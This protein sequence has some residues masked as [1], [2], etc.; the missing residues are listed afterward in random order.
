MDGA[1]A[2]RSSTPM[3]V[4]CS[5]HSASSL[6]ASRLKTR[7]LK[8]R[9][10]LGAIHSG[11]GLQYSPCTGPQLQRLT[12]GDVLETGDALANC[13]WPQG[14]ERRLDERSQ[15]GHHATSPKIR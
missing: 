1:F 8:G 11:L 5:S 12:D 14:R 7:A 2:L 9:V 15:R 4:A 10:V 6:P 13:R 3:A